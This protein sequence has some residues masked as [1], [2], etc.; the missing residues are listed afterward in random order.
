MLDLSDP[1]TTTTGR[2]APNLVVNA[3]YLVPGAS[4]MFRLTASDKIGYAFAEV[5]VV[6]NQAPSSGS[7]G[8]EPLV[9]HAVQTDFVLFTHSPWLNPWA[10]DFDDM[11]LRYRFAFEKGGTEMTLGQLQPSPN[12]TVQLPIGDLADAGAAAY[13]D[14]RAQCIAQCC[15]GAADVDC[16][17]AG[18]ADVEYA[19]GAAS[20]TGPACEPLGRK[21]AS[22]GGVCAPQ[23]E[24]DSCPVGWECCSSQCESDH[25]MRVHVCELRLPPLLCP[26]IVRTSR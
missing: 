19:A 6:V 17:S 14:G 7:F 9:G 22:C 8:I 20:Y 1:E 11:P 4:Y 25:L 23:P 16:A 2:N 18:A 10:D 24:C 13:A 3:G 5:F 15:S 12:R 21:F 26:A